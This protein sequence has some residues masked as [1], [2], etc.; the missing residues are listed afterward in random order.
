MYWYKL[1]H[2]DQKKGKK[3]GNILLFCKVE[4]SKRVF[5]TA[6]HGVAVLQ[7]DIGIDSNQR[8]GINEIENGRRQQVIEYALL[9]LLKLVREGQVPWAYAKLKDSRIE[10]HRR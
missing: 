5:V 3:I 7:R 8:D 1:Y 10:L 9:L 6:S 4:N 2:Q